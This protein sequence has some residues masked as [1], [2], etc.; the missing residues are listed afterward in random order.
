METVYRM[1]PHT[2][3]KGDINYVFGLINY[4]KAASEYTKGNS[5]IRTSYKLISNS[6]VEQPYLVRDY[7]LQWS[8]RW[9]H[10]YA[11]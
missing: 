9:A 11:E 1:I 8:A 3:K 4:K 5:F 7:I 2:L 10:S 6:G